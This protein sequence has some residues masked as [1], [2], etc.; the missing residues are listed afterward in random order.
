MANS[1]LTP[2][3]IAA[4]TLRILHNSSAF[5]G[6]VSQDLQT[7]YRSAP[8]PGASVTYRKPACKARWR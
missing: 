1:I 2:T 3:K 8:K 7:E 6:N 4:E 5:L